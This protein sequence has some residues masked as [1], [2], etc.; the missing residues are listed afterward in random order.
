MLVPISSF[1]IVLNVS[2]WHFKQDY[3]FIDDLF[4]VVI[5]V[6]QSLLIF[7]DEA[8]LKVSLLILLLITEHVAITFSNAFR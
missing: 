6:S 3:E 7:I 1:I 2:K 8:K 4:K 5:L